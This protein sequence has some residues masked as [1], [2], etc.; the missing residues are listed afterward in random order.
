MTYDTKLAWRVT[1]MLVMP[2]VVF[3]TGVLGYTATRFDHTEAKSIGLFAVLD[4]ST[5]FAVVRWC[6]S[7]Q[8][9][10]EHLKR[11]IYHVWEL[12]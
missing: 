9:L 7:R 10:R 2:A 5:T 11:I 6:I 8:T 12:L 3:I 4:G 1:G